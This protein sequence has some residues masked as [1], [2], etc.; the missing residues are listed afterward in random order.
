MKIKGSVFQICPH[1]F[2]RIK[3]IWKSLL[4]KVYKISDSDGIT[5]HLL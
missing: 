2:I 5:F 3:N 4:V 1:V